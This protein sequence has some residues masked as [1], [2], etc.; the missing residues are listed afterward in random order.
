MSPAFSDII[1]RLKSAGQITAADVLAMRGEVYGAPQVAREDVEALIAL[2]ASVH[3]CAPEWGAFVADAMVDYVVHQQDPEDY[4]DDAKAAWLMSACAG[5]LTK[6]GGLEALVRVLE[7]ATDAPPS[8][9][10][11][12][13]GKVKAAM[14]AAGRLGADDVALLRRVVF[15]G[16]GEGNVGVTREEADALFDIDAACGANADPAWPAFFAQ[17]ID[18]SLTAVSPFHVES[19]AAAQADEAWL[20]SRPSLFDF[21]K[22]I[23][24][25]PDV[26]GAMGDIFHPSEGER[27]EW[28]GADAQIEADEAAAAPI[29]DAEADWLVGRLSGRLLSAAAHA[30]LERLKAQVPDAGSRLKPLIDAA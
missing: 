4:V 14:V 29:T 12:V 16:A 10:A 19:R 8:L 30:L 23:V 1:G 26:G 3:D 7:A 17:A 25:K 24:A 27:R 6:D 11:F 15:A 2:D 18:D 22:Q 20:E 13:L 21:L 9:E 28:Q 5:P